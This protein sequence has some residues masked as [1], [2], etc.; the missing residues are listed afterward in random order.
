MQAGGRGTG[1]TQVLFYNSPS[2]HSEW[3]FFTEAQKREASNTHA[4]PRWGEGRREPNSV[5]CFTPEPPHWLHLK[6]DKGLCFLSPI[7]PA[8]HRNISLLASTFRRRN[9]TKR[10]V[11]VEESRSRAQK[12]PR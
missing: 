11:G 5:P 12:A 6:S 8:L 1:P 9:D 10:R 7:L 2:S 4:T 3:S